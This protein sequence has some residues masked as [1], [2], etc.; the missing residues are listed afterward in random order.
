GKSA[1][2][3]EVAD[4]GRPPAD[5]VRGGMASSSVALVRSVAAG[6]LSVPT[7]IRRAGRRGFRSWI[8]RNA[9]WPICD[10]RHRHPAGKSGYR[11]VLAGIPAGLCRV[12][13]GAGKYP[14]AASATDR[15]G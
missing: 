14:A 12:V 13:R 11:A 2:L 9:T 6:G 10:A 5:T 15:S 7:K 1:G 3:G 4:T 8:L